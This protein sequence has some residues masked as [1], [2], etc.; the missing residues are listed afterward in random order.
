MLLPPHSSGAPFPPLL[1]PLQGPP[2]FDKGRLP[3]TCHLPPCLPHVMICCLRPVLEGASRLAPR[4]HD[5]PFLQGF[6]FV[7]TRGPGLLRAVIRGFA[8]DGPRSSSQQQRQRPQTGNKNSSHGGNNKVEEVEE[9]ERR[10]TP[11]VGHT[12]SY[13]ATAVAVAAATGTLLARRG[14]FCLSL[15]RTP[16]PSRRQGRLCTTATSRH[17]VHDGHFFVA[18]AQSAE[19]KAPAALLICNQL[20]VRPRG[21]RILASA[22]V[23]GHPG[24]V[25]PTPSSLSK[26]EGCRGSHTR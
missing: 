14:P 25:P 26:P 17:L 15:A 23:L 1:T 10:K 7:P 24:H 2:P 6:S 3:H 12:C 8:Q 16:A 20:T 22:W 5:A 11:Q 4:S 9:R 13:H 21:G 19:C 18:L